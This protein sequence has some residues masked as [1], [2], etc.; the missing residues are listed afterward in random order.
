RC[1]SRLISSVAAR[2]RSR[3]SRTWPRQYFSSRRSCSA[4]ATSADGAAALFFFS[5]GSATV[6]CPLAAYWWIFLSVMTMVAGAPTWAR[7]SRSARAASTRVLGALLSSTPTSTTTGA[8]SRLGSLSAGEAGEGEGAGDGVE[9]TGGV[10]C[11]VCSARVTGGGV[12]RQPAPAAISK[13]LPAS[14]PSGPG[15]ILRAA[16]TILQPH[17]VVELGS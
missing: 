15:E 13:R 4:D 16:I 6:I 3:M 12:P 8:S 14:R 11:G 2:Q 17:D 9:A 10:G 1:S 7:R 5:F